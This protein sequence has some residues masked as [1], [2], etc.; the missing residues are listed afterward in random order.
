M[1]GLGG[2]VILAHSVRGFGPGSLDTI[3]LGPVGEVGYRKL[4]VHL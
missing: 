3:A 4:S 2:E 1:G